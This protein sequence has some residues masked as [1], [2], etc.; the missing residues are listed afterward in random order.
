M[1]WATTD[2]TST[3]W[4]HRILKITKAFT[5]G[6]WGWG[7]ESRHFVRAADWMER[8][9]GLLPP[10]FVDLRIARSGRAANFK[11]NAFQDI[12]G[13]RRY[14]WMPEL[15]N[16]RIKTK[17]GRRMQ[18]AEPAAVGE[19]LDR[20]I[21]LSKKR[22]RVIMFCACPQPMHIGRPAC[23]R[24]VVANLLLEEAKKRRFSLELSE[25]PGEKP[26]SLTVQMNDSQEKTIGRCTIPLGSAEGKVPPMAV[27]GWGSRVRFETSNAYTT[28]VTGPADIRR[29]QWTLTVLEDATFSGK[30]E[31]SARSR[32]F[33]K[34]SGYGHR[35]IG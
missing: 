27:L 18:I 21:E 5:W 32:N 4:G 8:K 1:A 19:L 11:G 2:W 16:K 15:G 7:S 3:I 31:A 34:K 22:R 23:H 9:R 29:G 20:I 17:R 6:Y 30:A 24:A 28:I 13:N 35:S 26:V 12:V 33:V 10:M 25:W 14:V